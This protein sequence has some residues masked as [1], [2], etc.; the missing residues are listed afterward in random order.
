MKTL[1]ILSFESFYRNIYCLFRTPL[2][3]IAGL[4]V[5]GISLPSIAGFMSNAGIDGII[6]GALFSAI[7]SGYYLHKKTS[8]WSSFSSLLL[9]TNIG[10]SL[11]LAI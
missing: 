8:S 2:N 7:L 3:S 9:L 6:I 11:A 5:L 1:K 4:A 10:L